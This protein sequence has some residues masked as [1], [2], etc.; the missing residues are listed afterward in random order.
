MYLCEK[1]NDAKESIRI[2]RAS[3]IC[4]FYFCHNI[5]FVAGVKI[6]NLYERTK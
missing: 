4:K 6:I 5:T 1:N 2:H 3:E